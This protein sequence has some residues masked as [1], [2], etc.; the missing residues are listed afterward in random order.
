MVVIPMSLVIEDNVRLTS[1]RGKASYCTEPF[2]ERGEANAPPAPHQ[3]PIV[4]DAIITNPPDEQQQLAIQ[5]EE[6]AQRRMQLA[7]TFDGRRGY[8][9]TLLGVEER[10]R[11]ITGHSLATWAIGAGIS[12]SDEVRVSKYFA[13]GT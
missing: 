12:S 10:I 11:Q 1:A 5:Q 2:D 6:S 3:T 9:F 8:L 7:A 4:G 13:R